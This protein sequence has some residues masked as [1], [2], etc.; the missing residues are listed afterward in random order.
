[1]SLVRRIARPLLASP[2]IVKGVDTFLSPGD[3]IEAHP[4]LSARLD[5]TL[6]ENGSPVDARTLLKIC[7]GVAAGAGVLFALNKAP[8]LSALLL[9]GTTTVGYAQLRPIWRLEGHER[10]DAVKDLLVQG[11]LIGGM[12]LATVDTDGKP[13]LAWR[14][15]RLVAKGRKKAEKA[16]NQAGRA[17]E[18]GGKNASK[19]AQDASKKAQ[20]SR[21]Q[22]R[23]RARTLQKDVA[24]KRAQIA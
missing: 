11:G 12:L 19:K 16:Q 7:G 9:L 6:D 18:K 8:R 22:A 21:K 2:F 3:E 23:R 14:A 20:A 5:R 4:D 10:V 13:S 24:K 15:E 17:L 1:M